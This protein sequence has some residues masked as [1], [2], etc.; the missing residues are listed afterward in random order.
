MNKNK[1]ELNILNA[2]DDLVA[3]QDCMDAGD[4]GKMINLPGH[5]DKYNQILGNGK[6]GSIIIV[7]T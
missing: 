7:G 3:G 2:D 4:L 6:S 1:E 5:N